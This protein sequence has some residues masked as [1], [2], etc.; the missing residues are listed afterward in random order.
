MEQRAVKT[1]DCNFCVQLVKTPTETKNDG[2]IREILDSVKIELV[3]EKMNDVK[4]QYAC[5]VYDMKNIKYV[6]T[7]Y[8][9]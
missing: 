5:P 2:R 6:D 4:A 9:M 8:N 1:Q 7:S 3:N